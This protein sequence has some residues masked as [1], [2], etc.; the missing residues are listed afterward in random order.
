MS[1][2]ALYNAEAFHVAATSL[3]Y[4]DQAYL[5][6]ISGRDNFNLQV[7]NSPLPRNTNGRIEES[8]F[9]YA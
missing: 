6:Y 8:G 1:A 4:M 5:R 2:E 7:V 3:M 9:R